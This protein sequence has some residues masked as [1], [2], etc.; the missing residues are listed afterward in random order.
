MKRSAFLLLSLLSYN[1]HNRCSEI[2]ETSSFSSIK[3]YIPLCIAVGVPLSFIGYYWYQCYK[4]DQK[5]IETVVHEADFA[6]NNIL[7][8]TFLKDY[9]SFVKT[10]ATSHYIETTVNSYAGHERYPFTC[11][12]TQLSSLLG[13]TEHALWAVRRRLSWLNYNDEYFDTLK[14]I[15]QQLDSYN[16]KLYGYKASIEH[17]KLYRQEQDLIN[18]KEAKREL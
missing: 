11:Y 18:A 16:S 9:Q 8:S 3:E 5:S 14:D 13:N 4:E 17:H 6:L 12:S 2:P 7:N 1:T 10:D 15:E